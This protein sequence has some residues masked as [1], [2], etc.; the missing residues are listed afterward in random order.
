[1]RRVAPGIDWARMDQLKA[2][3]SDP[4]KFPE[5]HRPAGHYKYFQYDQYFVRN[6]ERLLRLGLERGPRRRV[7]DLGCGF[8][9]FLLCCQVAGHKAVGLD[10]S[11]EMYDAV[12][13]V[14][15]VEKVV[16]RI[17]PFEP[18]PVI[19]G[20]P[21]DVVTAH[22]I[23]FDI[24]G[25]GGWNVAQ[26]DWFLRDLSKQM[27]ESSMLALKFNDKHGAAVLQ[28]PVLAYFE[29][30]GSAIDG[31]TAMIPQ[32]KAKLAAIPAVEK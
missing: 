18:L 3:F 24:V 8:G 21:F 31:R 4:A 26:W 13:D 22:E 20:G 28:G 2:R 23:N 11:V 7:L 32:L 29:Q 10:L 6:A 16:H 9:Y 27:A 30:L 19:E 25:K 15:G 17:E 12:L 5:Y 1:M 14:L